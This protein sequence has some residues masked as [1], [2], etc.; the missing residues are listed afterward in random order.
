MVWRP[1]AVVR[2]P[3]RTK[4]PVFDIAAV[5]A[6]IGLGWMCW[7]IY[8][9]APDGAADARLFRGGMFTASALTLVLIAAVSHPGARSNVVLGNP[10]LK[11]IGL[12]SYGLYLY[13]WP[14]FQAIRGL[15]G[16]KLTFSEFVVAMAITVVLTE[17]S[18]RFVETPI[19]TGSFGAMIRRARSNPR[20]FPR[21]ALISGAAVAVGM[22]LFAGAALATANVEQ[23]EIADEFADNA[24]STVDL[25]SADASVPDQVATPSTRAPAT[26]ATTLPATTVPPSTAPSTTS[27]PTTSRADRHH[28]RRC[29]GRH[30]DGATRS[31]HDG[32]RRSGDDRRHPRP[33]RRRRRP[34]PRSGWSPTLRRSPRS[35]C[36]RRVRLRRF[37]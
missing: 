21:R 22:S 20:P 11:W 19:R 35:R 23:S 32:A 6:L 27:A 28:R 16:N 36:H 9:V 18:Y 12:R 24:E 31:D 25:G 33:R 26:V 2:G 5:A 4:G 29:P 7:S 14:I 34:S 1:F 17:L 13:H 37:A 3:L 30:D 8:L 15:A 10:L